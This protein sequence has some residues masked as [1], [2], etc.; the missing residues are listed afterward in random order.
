[1]RGIGTIINV[2]LVV[3]GSLLGLVLKKAIPERLKESLVNALGLCTIA[4]GLTGIV[5]ASLRVNGKALSS[6]YIIVMVLCMALGTLIG[7]LIDIEKRLNNLGKFFERKFSSQNSTFSQGFVTA[8]LVFC[9]GS[10]T[11]LG[12]LNDAIMGDSTILITKSLLDAVMAVVFSSTLG[13]GVMFSALTVLFYQGL[14]T[15]CASFISPFLTDVV[16]SEM[17]LI[18]SLLIL[19]IGLNFLYK[20]S[21]KLSNM[22]PSMFLPLLY[23]VL[24]VFFERMF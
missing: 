9:V 4:I 15:L 2:I 10:M 24:E 5:T 14:I 19:G 18:G 23:Y 12:A 1:M 16:I 22:L 6:N 21:L 3:I 8:S 20:P 17:S 13:I 11:I 7:E